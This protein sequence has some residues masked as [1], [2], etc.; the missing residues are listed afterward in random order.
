MLKSSLLLVP[1]GG[2]ANRMR[3]IVSAYSLCEKVGGG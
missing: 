1:A 3:A 2:L